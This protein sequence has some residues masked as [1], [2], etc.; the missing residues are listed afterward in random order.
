VDVSSL[1]ALAFAQVPLADGWGPKDDFDG[2]DLVV[3]YRTIDGFDLLVARWLE[4]ET[5]MSLLTTGDLG[6]L[7]EMLPDVE[8]VSAE[9]WAAAE[10]S[11]ETTSVP[12]EMSPRTPPGITVDAGVLADG[13]DWSVQHWHS[14]DEWDVRVGDSSFIAPRRR[15]T[16]VTPV[17][18]GGT[19]LLLVHTDVA[20]A[21]AAVV[22]ADGS[23]ATA[24]LAATDPADQ[25]SFMGVVPIESAL[26]FTVEV[27]AADGTVVH[28]FAP[29]EPIVAT[30]ARA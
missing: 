3:G 10:R 18:V 5:Q 1:A 11:I 22:F 4:G 16:S 29:W 23:S 9:E 20:S 12:Q 14:S 19:T 26:P 28:R 6:D 27:M 13:T 7:L 2:D 24:P 17:T 8:L 25:T 30:G 21:T 15:S